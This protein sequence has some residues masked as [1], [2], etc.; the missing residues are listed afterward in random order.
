MDSNQEKMFF[1]VRKI[2]ELE[3]KCNVMPLL[4]ALLKLSKVEPLEQE[5]G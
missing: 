3:G 4:A 2:R 1:L 5:D